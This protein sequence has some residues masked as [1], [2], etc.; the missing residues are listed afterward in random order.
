LK[1]EHFLSLQGSADEY[2]HFR[3]AVA[4]DYAILA[5]LNRSFA[6]LAI[7]SFG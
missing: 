1:R 4:R 7:K 6:L 2:T 5:L 3:F